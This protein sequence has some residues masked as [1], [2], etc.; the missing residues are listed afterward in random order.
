MKNNNGVKVVNK[1]VY[2]VIGIC[3]LVGILVGSIGTVI[4]KADK[5]EAAN[6]KSVSNEKRID[7]VEDAIIAIQKDIQYIR[8]AIDKE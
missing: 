4:I 5:I 7:K 3:T 8:E 2:L 1:W 6:N